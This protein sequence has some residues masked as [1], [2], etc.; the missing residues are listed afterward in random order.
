MGIRPTELTELIE[1]NEMDNVMR[2]RSDCKRS[3]VASTPSQQIHAVD[4]ARVRSST[5]EAP[6]RALETPP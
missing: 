2:E 3:L 5:V 4:I 6:L 1:L